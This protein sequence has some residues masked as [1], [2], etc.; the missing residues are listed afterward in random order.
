MPSVAPF[1]PRNI[2]Q[3]GHRSSRMRSRA[4]ASSHAVCATFKRLLGG[5]LAGHHH[6]PSF[7]TPQA[8][9]GDADANLGAVSEWILHTITG[10]RRKHRPHRPHR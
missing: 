10:D 6:R 2:S 1:C 8:T 9:R 5:I 4:A 7:A 3:F